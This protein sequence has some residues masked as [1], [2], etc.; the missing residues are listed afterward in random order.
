[1]RSPICPSKPKGNTCPSS[2]SSVNPKM[3]PSLRH[4]LRDPVGDARID[5]TISGAGTLEPKSEV[6]LASS[7]LSMLASIVQQSAR[8]GYLAFTVAVAGTRLLAPMAISRKAG[9]ATLP[10]G[11]KDDEFD[12]DN[13]AYIVGFSVSNAKIVA[14]MAVF[15][16]N[17]PSR[18]LVGIRAGGNSVV[19]FLS[20]FLK[21][22]D[23]DKLTVSHKVPNDM[24]LVVAAHLTDRAP[25]AKPMP[26]KVAFPTFRCVCPCVLN[27]GFSM[28]LCADL[29]L[30]SQL[31][32]GRVAALELSHTDLATKIGRLANTSATNAPQQIPRKPRGRGGAAPDADAAS[33]DCRTKLEKRVKMLE[34][35]LSGDAKTTCTDVE[36]RLETL[37]AKFESRI[38]AL[39]TAVGAVQIKEEKQ[40]KKGKK[41]QAATPLPTSSL[42]E[43]MDAM[44]THTATLTVQVRQLAMQV[45]IPGLHLAPSFSPLSDSL[46]DLL[47]GAGEAAWRR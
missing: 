42:R 17:L 13:V 9:C 30:P 22:G 27:S 25:G 4:L 6:V 35:K 15:N 43:E 31:L 37:E 41:S 18:P 45:A 23:M 38:A 26:G 46:Y 16:E 12:R 24:L 21:R 34:S 2:P 40:P 20:D 5:C 44:I 11:I 8:G 33:A 19:Q 3:Y 14:L 32:E 7:G 1:M 39:E 28:P 36:S 29:R 47:H 10:K